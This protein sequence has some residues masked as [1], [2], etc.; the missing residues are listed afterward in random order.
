MKKEMKK[1]SVREIRVRVK[2][3]DWIIPHWWVVAY[4]I[5][6]ELAK[7]YGEL[8]EIGLDKK[9]QEVIKKAS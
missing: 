5:V 4:K 8:L 1:M 6:P 7:E 3:P 9:F 2:V